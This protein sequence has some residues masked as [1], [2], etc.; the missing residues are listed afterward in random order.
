MACSWSAG[1][2]RRCLPSA[3]QA[4]RRRSQDAARIHQGKAPPHPAGSGTA[5]RCRRI[6]ERHALRV[7][8]GESPRR[9]SWHT[10]NDGS[11]SRSRGYR[12][13]GIRRCMDECVD[14]LRLYPVAGDRSREFVKRPRRPPGRQRRSPQLMIRCG[15]AQLPPTPRWRRGTRKGGSRERRCAGKP[16]TDHHTPPAGEPLRAA[17]RRSGRWLS[18]G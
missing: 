14:C 7:G 13:A 2:G 4:S 12:D 15:V 1:T 3:N 17:N 6:A 11:F 9:A 18:P 5:F 8:D 10:A 16:D